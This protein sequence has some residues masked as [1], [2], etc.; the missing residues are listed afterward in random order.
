M[1]YSRL[2][3]QWVES[4]R[5]RGQ[6]F[7]LLEAMETEY[8]P[9][10]NDAYLEDSYF[11]GMVVEGCDFRLQLLFA[12]TVDHPSYEPPKPNEQ[13]CYRKGSILV[14]RPT[15]IEVEPTTKPTIH[16]D[17]DGSLDLGY[18]ELSRVGPDRFHVETAW[19]AITFATE[20]VSL[21]LA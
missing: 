13:H 7:K 11:L 4:G 3:P 16:T 1:R 18:L 9:E 5:W 10:F 17:P 20:K 19:F 14:Q 15:A 8:L 2:C 21:H 12:L 6:S